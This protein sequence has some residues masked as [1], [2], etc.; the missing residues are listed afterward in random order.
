MIDGGDNSYSLVGIGRKPRLR[1][2][3]ELATVAASTVVLVGL[4]AI[5]APSALSYGALSG[6]LP[7][8]AI[9]AIVGLGADAGGAAGRV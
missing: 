3:R 4:C 5:F 6:S 7:F 9:L 8:A 1:L 2:T